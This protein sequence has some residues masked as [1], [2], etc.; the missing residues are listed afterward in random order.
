MEQALATWKWS[1]FLARRA[2]PSKRV[3]HINMDETSVKLW[4]DTGPG[5]LKVADDEVRREVL[6][7]EQKAE[8]NKRRSCM[9]LMAFVADDPAV[10]QALPQ[11]L[12]VNERT[13]TAA[14]HA[15]LEQRWLDNPTF[16]ISRR[17][18][19]WVT[20][21]VLKEVMRL[22]KHR[23]RPFVGSRHILL[24]G[25][26]REWGHGGRAQPGDV[27]SGPTGHNICQRR[28]GRGPLDTTCA[29][30]GADV[31]PLDTA[32]ASGG[33]GVGLLDT[34]F[35]SGG[36]DVGPL[37]T[38]CA[39]GGAD[40]GPLAHDMSSGLRSA[41]P[42]AH[43]VSSEPTSAPPL[44][45]AVSI[46]PTSAPSLAHVVSSGPTSAPPLEHVVSSGP[47]SAPPLANVVS[48]GP[49]SAPPLA[50]AVSSGPIVVGLL[51]CL[52]DPMVLC[53]HAPVLPLHGTDCGNRAGTES[54]TSTASL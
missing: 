4:I 42:L 36:A 24:P 39:S 11:L 29:S 34:T 12:F 45:H 17:P 13:L 31:G 30:E 46:G 41:P 18:S 15:E 37:D 1:N 25:R 51:V 20:I 52:S 44:A 35:A 32:C 47:T 2:A 10:Q 40:V 7:G 16:F 33:A 9:S 5:L 21:E 49:T 38:T 50:H 8:L 48:S 26:V 6:T 53:V 22:L 3:V 27:G 23:L 14:Q 19:A 54:G 43:V 28:C